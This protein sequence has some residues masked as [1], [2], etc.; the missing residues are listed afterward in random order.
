M[1][2]YKISTKSIKKRDQENFPVASL[3]LPKKIRRFMLAFYNFARHADD[4]ADHTTIKQGERLKTLMQ[5][6]D[7]FID[8]NEMKMPEWGIEYL[9][10]VKQGHCDSRHG[11]ALLS[12]FIQDVTKHRY[13]S[14]NEL[15]DYCL[16]SAAPI[17]RTVLELHGEWNAN[18]EASDTLCTALQII[19]HLQDLKEDFLL[20]NRVYLPE[21]WF[22]NIED[23]G[24]N[25]GTKQVQ[26]AIQRALDKV[27]K[28][29]ERAVILPS[30]ISGV[31]LRAEISTILCIAKLLSKKLRKEDPIAENISLTSLEKTFCF[32]KGLLTSV[33]KGKKIGL[34]FNILQSSHSSFFWPLMRLP[35]ETRQAMVALYGFCRFLDDTVD[36]TKDKAA[37][38]ENIKFWK[39]EINKLYGSYENTNKPGSYPSHHVIRALLPHVIKF[40]LSKVFFEE[41]IKGQEM[42]LKGA[43]LRP[44]METLDLYCYRV[45]SC[46]GLL[47]IEI[48]G[49]K[50]PRTEEFAILLGKAMQLINILRDVRQDAEMGRIYLPV[51]MLKKEG[52]SNISPEDILDKKYSSQLKKVFEEIS[53]MAETYLRKTDGL[54]PEEDRKS[55]KPALLMRHIY[56]SYL[57][58]M[59]KQRWEGKK[60]K[61]GALDKLKIVFLAP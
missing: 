20:R 56:L 41:I 25:E 38:K 49:H 16:R 26:E 44:S 34:S 31:R 3:L 19:N 39:D 50:S 29:L 46:V 33:L 37:A 7:A 4:I 24:K 51:A 30:S 23:L 61:L 54:L 36:N 35:R 40:K 53:I 1:N 17:G 57:K 11:K 21:S 10:I 18:L 43:M 27:D 15:V 52:I 14:W 28:M 22:G 32:I 60:I 47:S 42:D 59:K 48:L 13:E 58:T 55:M 8:G 12:A 45:A 9:K 2:F 5:I 6:N